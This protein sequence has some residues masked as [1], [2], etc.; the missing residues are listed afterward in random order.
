MKGL[1][2]IAPL[3]PALQVSFNLS[4]IRRPRGKQEDAFNK[5]PKQVAGPFKANPMAP[6]LTVLMFKL[7]PLNLLPPTVL[8][9]PNGHS[10]PTPGEVAVGLITPRQAQIKL[11]VAIGLLPD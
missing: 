9:P 10:P 8:V 4:V 3:S 6:L 11:L 7:V 1:P 2:H 5:L